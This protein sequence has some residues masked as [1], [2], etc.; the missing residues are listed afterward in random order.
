MLTPRPENDEVW[1]A[2]PYAEWQDTLAT[3]HMWTQIV[4]KVK[5]ELTPFLNQ[6]WNVTFAVTARGLTTLTIPSGQRMFQVDFDFIDHRLAIHVSD[7]NS[8]GMPMLARSVA[9]F[10]REFMSVLESLGIQVK[11]NTHPVEVDNGIPFEDDQVH[12][13][14]DPL[15]ANRFWRILLGVSRL[16]ERYRTPF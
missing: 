12:S 10:Y 7:G 8:R 13:A 15:Y 16:L 14:Y 11:I 2:L 3:L 4:G 1:P 9:D 6:W 5:L